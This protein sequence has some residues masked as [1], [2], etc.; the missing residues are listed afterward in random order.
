MTEK[1]SQ[2]RYYILTL[3]TMTVLTVTGFYFYKEKS[4]VPSVEEDV[5]FNY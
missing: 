2:Y 5:Q 4:Q 3:V 1:I